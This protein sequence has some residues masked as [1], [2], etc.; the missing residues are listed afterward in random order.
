MFQLPVGISES[1]DNGDDS[2]EFFPES[3]Q[4]PEGISVSADFTYA[5][6]LES[7]E[8]FQFPVGIIE[9]ADAEQYADPIL[10]I[11]FQ[12]PV[13]IIES[14]DTTLRALR[15]YELLGV[16]VPRRDNRVRRPMNNAIVLHASNLF[17]FPVRI[18]ESAD[19]RVTHFNSIP[20]SRVCQ[21]IRRPIFRHY[22]DFRA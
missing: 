9:S 5:G 12:F 4:F 7:H 21:A 16:S 19:P 15:D 22:V 6:D 20:K 11:G 13:G 10:F 17:Q 18:I 2:D 8:K 1:A 3:F 14:A